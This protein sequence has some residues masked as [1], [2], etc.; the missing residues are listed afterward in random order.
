VAFLNGMAGRHGENDHSP[1]DPAPVSSDRVTLMA[2][3]NS[4]SLLSPSFGQRSATRGTG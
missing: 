3:T 4:V 1:G 2:A